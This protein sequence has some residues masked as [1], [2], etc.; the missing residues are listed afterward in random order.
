MARWIWKRLHK[1]F[2]WRFLN[3][4]S[5]MAIFNKLDWILNFGIIFLLGTGLLS[6]ASAA[7]DLFWRQLLWA[8]LAG[9]MIILFAKVDW[10][11]LVNYR[12][13]IYGI[14]GFSILLLILTYLIAPPI[15]GVRAWIP[16]GPLNFQTSEV[17]KFALIILYSSFFAKG[18]IGIAYL[19]KNFLPLIYFLIPAL[20]VVFQP[21]MG[22]AIILFCLWFGYL[23]VSGLPWRRIFLAAVIFIIAAGLMWLYVL[24]D[25]QKERVFGLFNPSHDPLG[26]NYS[27]IQSKIAIGS[28][29]FWG[30]GFGQG[31]QVQLGFLPEAQ[32]D[33]IFAAA[34]EEFGA[35]IGLAI[36][37]A[38]LLVLYE[39]IKI[40]MG[41]N[42]NFSKFFCLGTAIVF[43]AHFVL[44][45]GSNLGL[46]PVIGTP[47]PFLSY[48]GSN[49]LVNAI[50]VGM[51]QS[52]IIHR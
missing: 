48:G 40:G 30:K 36:A 49:L 6:L 51:A 31:T 41:A 52:I 50:L 46:L 37:G 11:P 14:Y 13:F 45:V 42:N 18:H 23:L 47:F 17:A 12:W 25:Y 35:A 9:G 10:R 15:R 21:D 5:C 7:P 33:F 8:A 19:K 26:V 2:L 20:L 22:T 32:T 24:K 39:L 38:F 28:A 27:V 34:I 16:I 4:I 43:L 3:K 29:G 44:N 1:V